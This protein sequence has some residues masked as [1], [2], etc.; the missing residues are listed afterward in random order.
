MEKGDPVFRNLAIRKKRR[1]GERS[2]NEFGAKQ[3]NAKLIKRRGLQI[4]TITATGVSIYLEWV[5]QL[6]NN[7]NRS[8]IG[9]NSY[10]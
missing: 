4:R 7:C 6:E 9:V 2:L 10:D 8:E 5:C 1:G 3:I